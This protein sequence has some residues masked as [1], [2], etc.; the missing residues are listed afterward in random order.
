MN[1]FICKCKEEEKE[2]KNALDLLN[3]KN[4]EKSLKKEE[5]KLINNTKYLETNIDIEEQMNKLEDELEIIDYPYA[6]I[7]DKKINKNNNS[8]QKVKSNIVN[9]NSNIFSSR[10]ENYDG[11]INNQPIFN[12]ASLKNESLIVDN[13]DYLSDKDR[14]NSSKKID[15][16]DFNQIQNQKKIIKNQSH[17]NKIDDKK[18][19]NSIKL[20]TRSTKD[21]N[22]KIFNNDS[23]KSVKS[24]ISNKENKRKIKNKRNYISEKKDYFLTQ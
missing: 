11:K 4:L 16:I 24:N 1:L 8:I 2:E 15:N 21:S 12:A 7:E 14:L 19:I 13:I 20:T 9:K 3:I 23:I 5:R 18:N 10:K 22:T 6:F 17:I